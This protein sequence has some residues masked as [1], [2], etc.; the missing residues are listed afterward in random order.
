MLTTFPRTVRQNGSCLVAYKGAPSKA[1]AWSVD[2]GSMTP[3]FGQYTNADGVAYAL[4]SPLGSNL[5]IPGFPNGNVTLI[6]SDGPITLV[7]DPSRPLFGAASVKISFTGSSANFYTQ[8][9]NF[10]ATAVPAATGTL[11]VRNADGSKVK[12]NLMYLYNTSGNKIVTPTVTHI[13][14]GWYAVVGSATFVGSGAVGLFG[15]QFSGQNFINVAGW[16]L[17]AGIVPP[18]TSANIRVTHVA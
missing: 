14:S 17:E 9:P 15:I 16:R 10:I 6:H 1:V 13:G 3:L 2:H 4:Y 7:M 11:Y 5:V 12:A 18:I 8:S